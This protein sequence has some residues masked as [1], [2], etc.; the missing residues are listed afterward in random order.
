MYDHWYSRCTSSYFL[1]KCLY[2]CITTSLLPNFDIYAPLTSLSTASCVPVFVHDHSFSRYTSSY[3][4]IN[5]VP[6]VVYE[7][8]FCRCAP[9][10]FPV[11]SKLCARI[12]VWP[13]PLSLYLLSSL[14]TLAC[15]Y[16]W[17]LPFSLPPFHLYAPCP[18]PSSKLW[19]PLSSFLFLDDQ[20]NLSLIW[21][22]SELFLLN[23]WVYSSYFWRYQP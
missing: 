22:L 7:H 17:S 9:F 11:N 13:L 23:N 20:R 12:C 5:S 10:Y 21:L 15:T 2:L 6:V 4:P 19:T 18:T 1:V 8:F 14:S 16:V 3:F